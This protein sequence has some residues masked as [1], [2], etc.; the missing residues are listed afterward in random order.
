MQQQITDFGDLIRNA[1]PELAEIAD[2]NVP[3]AHLPIKHNDSWA[4]DSVTC[5]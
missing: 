3:P 1:R 5:A 4:L 2:G